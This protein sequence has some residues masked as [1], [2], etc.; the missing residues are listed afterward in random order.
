M[1]LETGFPSKLFGNPRV[2]LG[3]G[4][5]QIDLSVH[6]G[7]RSFAIILFLIEAPLSNQVGSPPP[8]PIPLR[9]PYRRIILR[10]C[11][12]MTRWM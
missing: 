7:K 5:F 3:K 10:V 4:G 12:P 11:V 2:S 8:L 6:A 1:I 9:I